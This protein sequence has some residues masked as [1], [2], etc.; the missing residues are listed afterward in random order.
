MEKIFDFIKKAKPFIIIN[1]V[2][3]AITLMA[4]F[5]LLAAGGGMLVVLAFCALFFLPSVIRFL[6]VL[7]INIAA[8]MTVT[9]NVDSTGIALA[10]VAPVGALIG[11]LV[12]RNYK[13]ARTAVIILNVHIWVIAWAVSSAL[14]YGGHF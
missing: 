2:G 9:E 6:I 11:A 7:A 8:F 12:K 4:Y 13:H 10:S 14:Y 5:N 3:A 1:F